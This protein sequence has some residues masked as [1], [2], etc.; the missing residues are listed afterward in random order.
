MASLDTI[1]YEIDQHL[2]IDFISLAE[3][4]L[5][6]IASEKPITPKERE[7]LIYA[8]CVIHAQFINAEFLV[9]IVDNVGSSFIETE[10]GIY[11]VHPEKFFQL[12]TDMAFV[13]SQKTFWDCYVESQIDKSSKP[14]V[15]WLQDTFE[16]EGFLCAVVSTK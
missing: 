16:K 10:K 11:F 13:M 5:F 1:P 4:S 2:H 7:R 3:G 15:D 14:I 12:E 6:C 8:A 9:Q